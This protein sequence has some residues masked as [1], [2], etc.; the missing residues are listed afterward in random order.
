MPISF[1][2]ELANLVKAA[3]AQRKMGRGRQNKVITPTSCSGEETTLLTQFLTY[4]CLGFFK[5]SQRKELPQPFRTTDYRTLLSLLFL[6]M[7]YLNL[8]FWKLGQ[9]KHCLPEAST[10]FNRKSCL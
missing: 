10:V 5:N 8:P 6:V 2:R 7:F 4:D 3:Q 9:H 1:R